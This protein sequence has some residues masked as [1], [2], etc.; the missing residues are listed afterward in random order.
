MGEA[1]LYTRACTCM[2]TPLSFFRFRRAEPRVEGEG[3]GVKTLGLLVGRRDP[4]RCRTL[5]WEAL[6]P[7]SNEQSRSLRKKS[8]GN[9]ESASV[10]S[11]VAFRILLKLLK[12]AAQ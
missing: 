1:P 7:P 2:K 3:L 9:S 11:P 12:A 4:G 8:P 5:A 6:S 10:Y